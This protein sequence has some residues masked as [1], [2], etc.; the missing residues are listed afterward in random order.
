MFACAPPSATTYGGDKGAQV[1]GALGFAHPFRVQI[2]MWTLQPNLI[3][4]ILHSM[5]AGDVVV[6]GTDGL[7]DNCFDEEVASVIK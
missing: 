2:N 3:A 5:V 4:F 1:P 7:W 6:M